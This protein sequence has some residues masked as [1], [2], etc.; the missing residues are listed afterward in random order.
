MRSFIKALAIASILSAPSALAADINRKIIT[1]IDPVAPGSAS[2]DQRAT[3]I[4]TS[5]WGLGADFN[6][7][8][9]L[10]TGPEYWT[11][12]FTQKGS[13]VSDTVRRENMFPGERQKLDAIRLRWMFTAWEQPSSMRGWFVKGGYSYTRINSRGNR[14]EEGVS[15]SN[16]DAVPANFIVGSPDDDTSLVTDIRHGVAAGFGNRWLLWDQKLSITL[17]T[18][19]TGNFK[20]TVS[21][22]TKDPNARADY[23]EMIE[24]LPDTK[25][26]MRPLP[27][28]NLGLGW[29]W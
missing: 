20:R 26:S 4:V 28:A 6:L 17:G 14:Y 22:D 12:T 5:K 8:G 15:G 1:E 13:D 9:V 3:G 11:G 7:A 25:M 19:V 18:S 10:S 21:V 2:Y 27:E 16:G 24:K 23:D 29:A